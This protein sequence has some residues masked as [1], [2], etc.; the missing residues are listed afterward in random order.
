MCFRTE[1]LIESGVDKQGGSRVLFENQGLHAFKDADKVFLM[2]FGVSNVTFSRKSICTFGMHFKNV[3]SWNLIALVSFSAY[4]EYVYFIPVCI[5]EYCIKL[6]FS[7]HYSSFPIHSHA[8]HFAPIANSFLLLVTDL[9][10]NWEQELINQILI[11]WN[12]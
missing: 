2:V 9:Q 11:K 7:F 12:K 8:F 10:A 4:F 1:E 5:K 3:H 6:F